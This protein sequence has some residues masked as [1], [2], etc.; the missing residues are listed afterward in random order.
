ME[1]QASRRGS[2]PSGKQVLDKIVGEAYFKDDYESVTK[3]L[4]IENW[5]LPTKEIVGLKKFE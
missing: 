3:E 2:G 1:H 5:F 4:L